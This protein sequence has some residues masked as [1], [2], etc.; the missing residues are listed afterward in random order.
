MHGHKDVLTIRPNGDLSIWGVQVYPKELKTLYLDNPNAAIEEL[1]QW[2]E[3]KSSILIRISN[4]PAIFD[5]Q[6]R[7]I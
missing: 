3:K 2:L 7:R 1:I 4:E 6:G 5:E